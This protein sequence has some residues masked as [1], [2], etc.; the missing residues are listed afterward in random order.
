NREELGALE[1]R[2]ARVRRFLQ[3]ARVELEPGELAIQVEL[4]RVGRERALG[5][6]QLRA[7]ATLR[8]HA[9]ARSNSSAFRR[10]SSISIAASFVALIPSPPPPPW[11]RPRA[12]LTF[13]RCVGPGPPASRRMPAKRRT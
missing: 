8:S 12:A 2:V 11:A 9:K 1:Q 7:A 10:A 4:G 3:H 5:H 13:A 6:A